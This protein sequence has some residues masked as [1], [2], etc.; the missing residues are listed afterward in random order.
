MSAMN[1]NETT[2][3]WQTNRRD[4]GVDLYLSGFEGDPAELVGAQVAGFPVH[5]S[6]APVTD[7]IDP[8]DLGSAAA[9]VIQV[10]SDTP[11]SIK[12]FQKLAQATATPLIAAA[13][14][15]SLALVRALIRSGAH[16]VVPLPLS[17]EELDASIAPL[18]DEIRKAS[19][20]A[21]SSR[22]KLVTIVKGLGG[23]G[24][25]ALAGQLAI[26]FARHEVARD[27]EA[28]LIDLDV[29]FGDVAFQLGLR[30]KLSL[31]ELLEAGTRLDSALLRAT[32]THHSSG[33]AV[34]AAPPEMMPLESV[35][36]DH[37]LNVVDLATREF[38][39][40]FVDLP[41]NW[42]N[43][44]LSLVA[45]SDLVLLVTELSIA[46]LHRASKQ[47][48]LLE[49]QDLGELDVRVVANRFDKG[50]A[51]AIRPADIHKALGRGIA[52]TVAD[53]EPLM[54]AALDRGV[55]IGDLKRK[56]PLGKDI[57][58]LDA[59]VAAALGLER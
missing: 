51:R 14:D 44:S 4:L 42:T 41:S 34:I 8:Q 37:L 19:R 49:S 48:R 36:S 11:A 33:L 15:P 50:Q 39:T 23:I 2:R 47:L 56:S 12:R 28:C 46:G 32:T 17:L 24:A 30:P 25:T 13:Y 6:I 29:Q 16:D 59:G 1:P 18:R 43:W 7:W 20:A 45:R 55:P 35:S 58:T 38:G 5:L 27:R 53:D 52:Y 3:T 31:H 57:D 22:S 54:R 21:E 10:D 9:A 26:R 40:V